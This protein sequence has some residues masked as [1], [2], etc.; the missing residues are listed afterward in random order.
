MTR[1]ETKAALQKVIKTVPVEELNPCGRGCLMPVNGPKPEGCAIQRA[2]GEFETSAIEE[3]AVSAGL[4]ELD[5]FE[6][7][8]A[9]DDHDLPRLRA[10]IEAL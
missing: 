9:S 4:D 3:L 10:L 2:I 8:E 6:I 7:A 1:E 5:A